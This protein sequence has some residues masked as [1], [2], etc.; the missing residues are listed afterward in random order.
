MN[1]GHGYITLNS[2]CHSSFQP[3]FCPHEL[4]CSD[5]SNI[6]QKSKY[7]KIETR[8]L[9]IKSVENG[10]TDLDNCCSRI[11][12]KIPPRFLWIFYGFFSAHLFISNS[13]IGKIMKISV[14]K[15][16]Y[17]I[18]LTFPSNLSIYLEG[19][20]TSHAYFKIS[21]CKKNDRTN[22][23]N[24]HRFGFKRIKSKNSIKTCKNKNV[25]NF[26]MSCHI[27]YRKKFFQVDFHGLCN[28]SQ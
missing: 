18:L 3:H 13:N 11:L 16:V 27:L 24:S 26:V 15:L 7:I 22:C 12:V 8:S 17:D 4:K 5:F 10:W 1:I 28:A 25:S 9:V 19:R 20:G 23:N 21:E 6:F 2:A 14:W